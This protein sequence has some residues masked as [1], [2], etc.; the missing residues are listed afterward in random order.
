MNEF[1]ERLQELIMDN[2][3]NRLQLSKILKISST[4]INGYFNNNYYPQINIALEMARYFNCSLDYLFGLSDEIKNNNSNTNEFINNFK[5]L[6]E[7][8]NL[9]IAKCLK[10]LK[11]SEYNYYRWKNG[12]FPKTNNLIDIA[13]YFDISIDWLIGNVKKD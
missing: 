4:T 13:K 1:Q 11:M 2:N 5:F 6:I 3:L 8:K 10:Q 7:Q 9:S 12:Q